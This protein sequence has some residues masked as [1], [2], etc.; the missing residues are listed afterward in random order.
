MFT[1][2]DLIERIIATTDEKILERV[3]KVLESKE[4]EFTFTPEHLAMLEERRDRRRQGRGKGY[5]LPEVKR[6]LK[7]GRK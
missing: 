2:L 4:G 5:S 6:M 3:G 7:N 1:K